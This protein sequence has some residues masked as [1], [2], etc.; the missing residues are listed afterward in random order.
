MVSAFIGRLRGLEHTR[1][2]MEN[3]FRSSLIPKRDVEH[4][5]GAIFLAVYAA[6]EAMVEDLFLK[7]LT[8]R[9]SGPRSVRSK[10]EFGSYSVARAIAFGGRPYVDWVPYDNT[11]KRAELHFYGARPFS[12]LSQHEKGVIKDVC[13]I[14]NAVAH[15]SGY[16]R[17]VFDRHIIA[18]LTLAPRERTPTAFLRSLHSSAPDVTRYEELVSELI[19]IARN[20]VA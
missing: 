8:R 5:Y 20:L 1:A 9:V 3:L 19:S 2:N 17:K 4:L 6:F 11:L 16:A 12:K 15:Q 14:R 10:A 13:T 7:L 18:R